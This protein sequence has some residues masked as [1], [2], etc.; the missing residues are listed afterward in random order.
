MKISIVADIIDAVFSN[1]KPQPSAEKLD[2]DDFFQFALASAGSIIRDTYYEERALNN[3]DV[4][5]YIASMLDVKEAKV[6]RGRMGIKIID[7]EV[8]SLPKNLGI[9]NIYPVFKDNEGKVCDIDYKS[10]FVRIQPGTQS[11]YDFDDIGLNG[12]TQ[13]GTNPVLMC[14]DDVEDVAIEGIFR[15]EDFDIP[16][17]IARKVINDVLGPV[18][19]VAGFPADPTDNGDPNVKLMNDK[20][21][22]AQTA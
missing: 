8:L 20:I 7:L 5:S 10:P 13:R 11:L 6:I 9:F 22:S 14:G 21:A 17:D 4:S 19:K 2:R 15:S 1:G 16:L 3:G 12:F 18:L